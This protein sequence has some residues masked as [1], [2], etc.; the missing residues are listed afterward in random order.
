MPSPVVGNSSLGD[1]ERSLRAP[2]SVGVVP[3]VRFSLAIVRPLFLL[4]ANLQVRN[5]TQIF[6]H[7]R[8]SPDLSLPATIHVFL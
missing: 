2:A 1:G 7:G 6:G 5:P 3:F 4:R 8:L